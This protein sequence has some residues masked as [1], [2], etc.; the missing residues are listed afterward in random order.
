MPMLRVLRERRRLAVDRHRRVY[1][2]RFLELRR[3]LA[4]APSDR[5]RVRC[6]IQ[7]RDAL[8]FPMA[9]AE[10]DLALRETRQLTTGACLAIQGP[11]MPLSEIA[12]GV[13]VI[14]FEERRLA[15]VNP[16]IPNA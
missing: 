6:R 2:Y 12:D 14:G 4:A 5:W 3:V 8:L 1:E 11:L 13:I 7:S 16:S 15:A 9:G 10:P